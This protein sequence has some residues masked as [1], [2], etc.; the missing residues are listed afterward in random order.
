MEPMGPD[1]LSGWGHLF[2][3]KEGYEVEGSFKRIREGMLVVS[4]FGSGELAIWYSR[5]ERVCFVYPGCEQSCEDLLVQDFLLT[6]R[7]FFGLSNSTS[8]ELLSILRP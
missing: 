8:P 4:K 2:N 6:F 1:L 5:V 3:V 7:I